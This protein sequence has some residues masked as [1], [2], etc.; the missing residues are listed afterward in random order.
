MIVFC[1]YLGCFT[2]LCIS[3]LSCAVETQD[4]HGSTSPSQVIELDFPQDILFV[5]E[6]L[7]VASTGYDSEEWRAGRVD[8]YRVPSLEHVSQHVVS[9][10][11]PQ[12]LYLDDDDILVVNTGTYDFSD[13]DDPKAATPGSIDRIKRDELLD[14]NSA[15]ILHTFDKTVFPS[16]IDLTRLNERQLGITSGLKPI[17]GI[18]DETLS[19]Q[20]MGSPGTTALG[21]FARWRDLTFIVDFNTDSAH[22]YDST[23]EHVCTLELGEF[24]NELE[25]A[26]TPVI[27]GDSLYY[28]L[29]LS[30]TLRRVPLDG[31]RPCSGRPTTV[32]APL[33]QVPNDLHVK[34]DGLFV[35][36]SADNNLIQYDRRNGEEV[37][38]YP[39][40]LGS[41]PWAA[42]FSEDGRYIAV[43]EW[44]TN[45]ITLIDRSSGQMNR[46]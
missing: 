32:V 29:A 45:Q 31:N 28:I 20:S 15:Q 12:H 3:L 19:I 40:P 5:D 14:N 9:K 34:P 39:L 33:G 36:H 25:G 27:D 44:A 24:P 8:V 4:R 1:K 6:L 41:N 38:R 16:P 10:Y 42:A 17:F 26:T 13:F 43:T 2:V 23:N 11:N 22:V 46:L 18:L 7:V 21:R 35:V 37:N 30:G